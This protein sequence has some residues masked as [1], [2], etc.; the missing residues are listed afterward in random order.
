MRRVGLNYFP[1]LEKDKSDSVARHAGDKSTGILKHSANSAKQIRRID[2][3]FRRE[4]LKLVWREAPVP[5][6]IGEHLLGRRPRKAPDGGTNHRAQWQNSFVDRDQV[7]NIAR[8]APVCG[9]GSFVDRKI[10]RVQNVSEQFVAH[11]QKKPKVAVGNPIELCF[12]T[13]TFDQGAPPACPA[14]RR[15]A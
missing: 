13:K 2:G 4:G 12:L 5:N 3:H 1:I 15:P 7:E 11:G 10:D 6:D 9:G 14:R 8:H